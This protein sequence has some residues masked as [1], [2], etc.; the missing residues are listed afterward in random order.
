MPELGEEVFGTC[1]YCG[2]DIRTKIKARDFEEGI[3]VERF[4]E[5]YTIFRD[6]NSCGGEDVP[7]I[8]A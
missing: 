2:A 4:V 3:G 1:A 8:V 5:L 6:C 7:V